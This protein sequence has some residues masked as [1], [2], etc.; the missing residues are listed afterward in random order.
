MLP[1]T[2][3]L[4]TEHEATST[5]VMQSDF[6]LAVVVEDVATGRPLIIR[7]PLLCPLQSSDQGTAE[8][9]CAM[10]DEQTFVPLFDCLREY[11]PLNFDIRTLD[12]GSDNIKAE[13]AFNFR[14]GDRLVRAR[15]PCQVHITSTVQK[16]SQKPIAEVISGIISTSLAMRP[17]KAFSKLKTA[18]AHVLEHTCILIAARPPEH[19]DPQT[20]HREH[21]LDLCLP[22]TKKN[23]IRRL[24]LR[25]D[26]NGS[27][28]DP[29]N[30][31]WYTLRANPHIPTWASRCVKNLMPTMPRTWNR[32]RWIRSVCTLRQFALPEACNS[33]LSRAIPIWV[34]LLG[35]TPLAS[36]P[37]GATDDGNAWEVDETS[38]EEEP[39]GPAASRGA[40]KTP[41]QWQKF[42]SRQR[43]GA[44]R[45]GR[46]QPLCL[47]LIGLIAIG[48]QAALMNRQ[49]HV[50]SP[51]W[52]DKQCAAA[53]EGGKTPLSR[54]AFCFLEEGPR[55]KFVAETTA[56]LMTSRP[57][58]ALPQASRTIKNIGIAFGTVMRA[59]GGMYHLLWPLQ[60][61]YPAKLFVLPVSSNPLAMA[62][63][64]IGDPT[65]LYDT[66]TSAI[67]GRYS[68]A[69]ALSSPE[70]QLHQYVF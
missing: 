54:A 25:K 18:C 7:I 22:R 24:A 6:T 64:I 32:N 59:V 52:Q 11:F 34:A 69:E 33:I 66:V 61:G 49:L 67:V 60:T 15:S 3:A 39:D 70:P 37:I 10:I 53:I 44:L 40:H 35:G 65:C 13:D 27:W 46:M 63:D 26:L 50:S 48:P 23:D 14:Y 17:S 41:E 20:V 38:D 58:A 19:D 8:T 47:L 51:A 55:G 43:R 30:T 2:E 42:N 31:T 56:L 68:T 12:K 36:I 57:W 29:N 4:A 62:Q 21:V 5:K 45:F 28:E 1:I 16:G 9:I